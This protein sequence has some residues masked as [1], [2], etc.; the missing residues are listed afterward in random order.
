MTTTK[1]VRLMVGECSGE[2]DLDVDA[3][4]YQGAVD[5]DGDGYSNPRAVAV[6]AGDVGA[7]ELVYLSADEAMR[8]AADWL[9]RRPYADF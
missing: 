4:V 5:D 2:L 8:D 1:T 7:D 9:V 6:R 3:V